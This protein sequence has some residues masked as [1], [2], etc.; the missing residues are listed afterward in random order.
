MKWS[1]SIKISCKK[2]VGNISFSVHSRN[3]S[4]FSNID[5]KEIKWIKFFIVS[6][7]SFTHHIF[8]KT[9][10]LHYGVY[11]YQYLHLFPRLLHSGQ[12]FIFQIY[13]LLQHISLKNFN[14]VNHLLDILRSK[15]TLYKIISW[16]INYSDIKLYRVFCRISIPYQ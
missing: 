14:H 11:A 1:F 6:Y 10:I 8:W 13:Y 15:L 16:L 3:I 9:R 5:I 2:L 4:N 12:T 7:W